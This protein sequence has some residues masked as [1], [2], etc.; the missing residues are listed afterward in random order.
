[1]I[2]IVDK[3]MPREYSLLTCNGGIV[4]CDKQEGAVIVLRFAEDVE[5]L[6]DILSS[7]DVTRL[8][9]NGSNRSE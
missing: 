7:I 6:Q 4:I 1:M 8:P 3:H 5:R 2:N 9:A